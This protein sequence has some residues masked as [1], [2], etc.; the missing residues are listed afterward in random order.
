[1]KK[2]DHDKQKIQGKE[3][4]DMDQNFKDSLKDFLEWSSKNIKEARTSM[5]TPTNQELQK[6]IEQQYYKL[7]LYRYAI[8]TLAILLV[9]GIFI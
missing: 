9:I 4:Q 6:I 5:K 8:V 7:L 3:K 1:M 2:V